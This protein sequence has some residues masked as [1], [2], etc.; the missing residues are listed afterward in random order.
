MFPPREPT[1]FE[2]HWIANDRANR[3]KIE[4]ELAQW[5]LNRLPDICGTLSPMSTNGAPPETID[6]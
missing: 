5:V 4:A 2:R 3:A 1:E 6:K